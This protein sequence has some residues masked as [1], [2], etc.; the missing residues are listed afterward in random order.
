MVTYFGDAPKPG[1]LGLIWVEAVMFFLER[2]RRQG[3]CLFVDADYVELVLK[4]GHARPDPFRVQRIFRVW[5]L[6]LRPVPWAVA[7]M[8]VDF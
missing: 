5:D 4:F 6:P 2:S 1:C 3:R 8:V 7:C